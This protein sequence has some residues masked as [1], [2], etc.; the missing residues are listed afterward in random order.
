MTTANANPRVLKEDVLGRDILSSKDRRKIQ[1]NVFLPAL[2]ID[3]ASPFE[4]S[5]N[6]LAPKPGQE[7]PADRPD[8]VPDKVIARISDKRAKAL[9]RTFYGWAVLRVCDAEQNGC[10]VLP[11]PLPGNMQHANIHLP[12]EARKD[13]LLYEH[14]VHRLARSARWRPRPAV[15]TPNGEGGAR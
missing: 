9:G 2:F 10:L 7:P 5:V 8:L 11:A 3:R 15:E 4:L 12:D 1:K 14:H 6:R 13:P